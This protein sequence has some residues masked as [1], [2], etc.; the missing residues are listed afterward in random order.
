MTEPTTIIC[1]NC[2]TEINPN[3][4]LAASLIATTLKQYEQQLA[5]SARCKY[6]DI[7]I[8]SIR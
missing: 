5:Q 7:D 8:N 2:N 6:V 1:P 3:D 4:S